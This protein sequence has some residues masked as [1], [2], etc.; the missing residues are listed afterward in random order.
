M[1]R[2]YLLRFF[3]FSTVGVFVA[4]VFVALL[5]WSPSYVHSSNSIAINGYAWSDNV[6]WISMSGS[7]YGLSM[8]SNGNVTGYAWSDAI[9]WISANGAD[10]AACQ[11]GAT[12]R[13]QSGVW[14]G[15]LRAISGNTTQAGGWDGCIS[16]SGSNYAVSYKQQTGA[17]SGWAWGSTV[18]GWIDFSQVSTAPQVPECNNTQGNFC[19]G[20]SVYYRDAQCNVTYQSTCSYQCSAGACVPPPHAQGGFSDGALHVIPSIVPQGQTTTVS[21]SIQNVQGI[22][23]I[24]GTNGDSWQSTADNNN[25]VS[26]SKTSS[27]ITKQVIYTLSCTGLDSQTYTESKTVNI[28]PTFRE[29]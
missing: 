10:I 14:S 23:T 12:S 26:S 1:V 11:S 16:M 9:G 5:L 28:I 15:W 27:A 6:G 20:N 7:T 2:T 8:D 22:C 13:I 21:W 25:S 3:I 29:I 24:T 17:F 18:V 4:A 19:Q